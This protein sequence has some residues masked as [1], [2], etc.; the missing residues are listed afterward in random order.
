MLGDTFATLQN[1][2]ETVRD[3]FAEKQHSFAT[4]QDTFAPLH[5]TSFIIEN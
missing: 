3:T 4:L 1:S 2:F 5:N